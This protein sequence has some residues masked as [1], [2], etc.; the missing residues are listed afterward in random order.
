MTRN[1]LVYGQR[2]KLLYAEMV[3]FWEGQSF[4][5]DGKLPYKANEY[6]KIDQLFSS[7]VILSTFMTTNKHNH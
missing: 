3:I 4:N 1:G 2:N 5:E 7:F 6:K